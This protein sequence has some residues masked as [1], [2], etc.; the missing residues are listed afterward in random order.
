VPLLII[1]CLAIGG[2]SIV[3]ACYHWVRNKM[4]GLPGIVL[5][6]VGL[7]LIATSLWASVFYTTAQSEPKPADNTA[8]I[9]RLLDDSD[10]KT[11]AAIRESNKRSDDQV[12]QLAKQLQ[13]R[14]DN[15]QGQILAIRT[16]LTE[17]PEPQPRADIRSS[18]GK[19]KARPPKT[20]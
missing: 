3:S 8:A 9:Q 16:A 12:Q 4:F 11:L 13:D 18:D 10:A 2:L 7:C 5:S 15:I 17:R 20:R 1:V 14:D 19:P 6:A